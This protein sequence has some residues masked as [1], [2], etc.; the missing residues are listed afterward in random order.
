MYHYLESSDLIFK[1]QFGFRAK[2]TTNHAL[3]SMTE[4][5]KSHLD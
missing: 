3:R 2:H 1:R 5:I 4:D